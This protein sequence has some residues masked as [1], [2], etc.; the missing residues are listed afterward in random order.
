LSF[1]VGKIRV[2]GGFYDQK[3]VPVVKDVRSQNME[4]NEGVKDTVAI[5][6][7][8]FFN[9]EIEDQEKTFYLDFGSHM[10]GVNKPM[11]NFQESMVLA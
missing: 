4:L 7:Y 1:W 6:A 2:L 10:F 5:V 8:G 3:D 11:N 9:H